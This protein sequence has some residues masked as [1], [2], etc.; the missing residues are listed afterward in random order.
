MIWIMGAYPLNILLEPKEASKIR[1]KA[2]IDVREPEMYEKGHIE[3]AVNFPVNSFLRAE[4][5]IPFQMKPID[6]LIE[7]I[8]SLGVRQDDPI[9]IYSSGKLPIF[10]ANVGRL[11]FVLEYLG[12][13]RVFVL[14]GGYEAWV[15]NKL[16]TST[17]R[18]LSPRIRLKAK[19]D[20]SL[21]VDKNFV[22]KVLGDP[23][24]QI[25]D[26]RPSEYYFGVYGQPFYQR[27]GHIPQAFSLPFEFFFTKVNDNFYVL[28]NAESVDTILKAVVNPNAKQYIFYCNTGR[29]A[30]LGY[31]IFRLM[32]YPKERLRVF[33]G[34]FA[35]WSRDTTLPVVRFKWY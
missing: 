5:G 11:F 6:T 1:F 26:V 3:G 8:S 18:G 17:K 29:E 7:V 22:L 12:F 33:E 25:F 20:S 15:E 16:P 28:K 21:I 32:G 4:D 34:S 31:F 9:L 13:E 14:N 19:P 27:F 23:N 35:V 10:Y 30:S 2:I 24:Y